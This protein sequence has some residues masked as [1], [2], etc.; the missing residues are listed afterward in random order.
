MGFL[1]IGDRP[2][3]ETLDPAVL[4][5]WELVDSPK[6]NKEMTGEFTRLKAEAKTDEARAQIAQLAESFVMQVLDPDR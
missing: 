4:R 2:D 1:K 5:A 6:K 3:P